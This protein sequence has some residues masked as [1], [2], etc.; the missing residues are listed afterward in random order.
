MV[1]GIV[2][3]GVTIRRARGVPARGLDVD[4]A[5]G[6]TLVPWMPIAG[7]GPLAGELTTIGGGRG[8]AV[9]PF[10]EDGAVGTR[11]V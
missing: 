3:A 5:M 1:R 10:G 6:C 2:G 8:L 11:G 9:L 4:G 7:P